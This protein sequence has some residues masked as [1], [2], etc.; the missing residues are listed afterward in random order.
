MKKRKKILALGLA[1]V[2]AIGFTA[3]GDG[4]TDSNK[5]NP[6]NGA[7]S[8]GEKETSQTNKENDPKK[9]T[10][11]DK[12]TY[13]L[14]ETWT[15]DGQWSLTVTGVAETSDRNQYSEREPGA[16]YIVDYT[17][18]NIGYESDPD[19]IFFVMDETIVDSASK[20]GYSYP[21][22][23][24]KYATRVPIGATCD[25]QVCIGVENPGDFK[26]TTT[27]YDDSDTEQRATFEVTV[28]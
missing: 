9:G 24:A 12:K 16:V 13:K 14:G 11:E 6:G 2:M 4:T 10:V 21:G 8:Q 22:D 23:V 5:G 28:S 15:V 20:I 19:G 18:T 25:A 26:I 27:L 3:C 7:T 17:Y 1:I